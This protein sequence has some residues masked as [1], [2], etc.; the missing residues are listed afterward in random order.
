[1]LES[2]G[3]R[4]AYTRGGGN[5][6]SISYRANY[7]STTDATSYTFASS[8]IG[9]ATDRSIVVVAI[10]SRSASSSVSVSSVT[11]G[12]VSATQAVSIGTLFITQIWYATGVS[13][14]TGDIVVTM[15]TTAERCL[16]S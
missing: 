15:N 16:I 4:A 7:S 5:A 13:G 10:H 3:L 9:T 12:G 11:I 14:T 1:M 8:D 2:Q 6:A